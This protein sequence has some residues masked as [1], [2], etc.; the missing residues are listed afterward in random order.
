ME[1][2]PLGLSAEKGGSLGSWLVILPRPR[3]LGG[4]GSIGLALRGLCPEAKEE[5]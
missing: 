4:P 5:D 1:F 2:G 3:G